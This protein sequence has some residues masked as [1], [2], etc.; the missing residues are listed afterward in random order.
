MTQSAVSTEPVYQPGW[1]NP[2][3]L[4]IFRWTLK[5]LFDIF[6]PMKAYGKENLAVPGG[7]IVAANHMSYFDAPLMFVHIPPG[8]RMTAFGAD[9]YKSYPFFA[10]ILR[11]V[12]VIWVNRD[13]PS[14]AS[15]K[16]AVQVLRNGDVLGVAPEGTR[17]RDT[18]ALQE[19]KTGAAY[20]AMTA[21]VPILPVAVIHTDLVSQDLKHLPRSHVSISFGKP[22]S[23]PAL[24]RQERDAKLQEYTTELMCQIAALLPPEYRG[25]Y[26]DHPRVKQLLNEGAPAGLTEPRPA[27]SALQGD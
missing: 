19:G 8:R 21:G 1:L 18:H 10:F 6:A 11:M 20:L 14:P 3:G 25:V 12:G 4:E 17:S 26:T 2:T 13:A 24:P 7:F 27:V 22:I 16:A 5:T 15:I 23:I 9:K